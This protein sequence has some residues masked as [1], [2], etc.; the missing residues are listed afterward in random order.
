MLREMIT[1]HSAKRIP[2]RSVLSRA[3]H[4]GGRRM[5]KRRFY[6]LGTCGLLLMALIINLNNQPLKEVHYTMPE[7]PYGIALGQEFVGQPITK[8]QQELTAIKKA[9]FT[10]VRFEVSWYMVQPNSKT[11]FNWNKYDLLFAAVHKSGLQPLAI[12]MYTPAWA[13]STACPKS[14]YCPPASPQDFGD[15]A[16]AVATRYA[17]DGLH[18]YEIWNEE[19]IKAFWLPTPSAEQYVPI[20]QAAYTSIKKVDVRAIVISGGMSGV[21]VASPGYIEPRTYLADMYKYGLK[22]YSDAIGYHAY[23]DPDEPISSDPKNAWAKISLAPN[24]LQDIM[25]QNGDTN[26]KIWITEYGAPTNGS[27]DGS[28]GPNYK[29]TAKTDHVTEAYQTTLARQALTL[30]QQSHV[31]QSFYWYTWQDKG[32]TTDTN[33]NFYGLNDFNGVSKPALQVF[34]GADK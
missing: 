28:T 9:G 26:K 30:F 24:S 29:R 1:E 20:L 7:K 6:I 23:T 3:M 33:E 13:R 31:I 16:A 10:D 21:S 34:E 22:N 32:T 14:A 5:Y 11:Q 17:P 4:K 19:N 12:I 8:S 25:Q 27:G 18:Q 15:F 2:R